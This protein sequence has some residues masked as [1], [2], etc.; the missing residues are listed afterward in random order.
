ML[1][2]PYFIA[3][4]GFEFARKSTIINPNNEEAEKRFKDVDSIH[5]PAQSMRLIEEISLE[6]AKVSTLQVAK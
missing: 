1:A 4:S 2:H 5:I 6:E 3:V